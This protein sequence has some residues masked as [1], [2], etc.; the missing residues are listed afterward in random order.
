MPK[1]DKQIRKEKRRKAAERKERRDGR[2]RQEIGEDEEDLQ[3]V[4]ADDDM[5]G[6]TPAERARTQRKRDLIRAGMGAAL[7]GDGDAAAAAAG[8]GSA[9][10]SR[11]AS[12]S[13]GSGGENYDD[14]DRA[15][16]LALGT[17]MLRRHR[18]KALADA[19]YNRFAWNDDRNLP[20]WFVDDEQQH[21]RPQVPIPKELLEQMRQKFMS[22]AAKPIKKVAEARARKRK[23]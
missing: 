19:A 20:S 11:G 8:G 14:E 12:S 6:M 15:Q 7:T 3:V 2:R 17:M 10:S 9:P 13:A 21:Y 23:R 4:A 5:A 16:Q 1:T 22:L 18:A